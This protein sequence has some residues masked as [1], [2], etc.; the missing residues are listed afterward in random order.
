M[1]HSIDTRKLDSLEFM[2]LSG[3][4][5]AVNMIRNRAKIINLTD[6]LYSDLLDFLDGHASEQYHI[7]WDNDSHIVVYFENPVDKENTLVFLNQNNY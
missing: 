3:T 2:M 4:Q 1:T 7:R 6:E 5:D